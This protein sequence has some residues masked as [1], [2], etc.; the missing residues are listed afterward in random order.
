M[1]GFGDNSRI[2]GCINFLYLLQTENVGCGNLPQSKL[3]WQ[4]VEPSR[5]SCI[6]VKKLLACKPLMRRVE[7]ENSVIHN[8]RE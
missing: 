2:I 5:V 7:H 3:V 6:E 1:T 4:I 8:L